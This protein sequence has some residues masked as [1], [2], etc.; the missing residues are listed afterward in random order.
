MN[1]AC[2]DVERDLVLNY[3]YFAFTIATVSFLLPLFF[4]FARNLLILDPLYV[5]FCRGSKILRSEV[6]G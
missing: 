6:E 5:C 3:L 1:F 4:V 2:G